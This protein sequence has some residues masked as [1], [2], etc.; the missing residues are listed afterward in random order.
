MYVFPS[1]IDC[2]FFPFLMQFSPFFITS[3]GSRVVSQNIIYNKN[4]SPHAKAFFFGEAYD[5]RITARQKERLC[6]LVE[7]IVI[8]FQC[9]EP[10]SSDKTDTSDKMRFSSLQNALSDVY[11]SIHTF[12]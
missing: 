12:L 4:T 8:P 6:R 7:L 2:Y 9:P 5:G 3:W 11:S 10:P 1:E